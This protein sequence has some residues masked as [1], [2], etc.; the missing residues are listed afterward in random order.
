MCGITGFISKNFKKN[1]L[2]KM[3]ESLSHRGPDASGQ[4]FDSK[5]GIALGHR[6][7]SILD[8]SN[9]ANQPM[10]SHCE[11]YVMVFNGEI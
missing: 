8:L 3:T 10:S 6:R 4:F 2:V 9:T 1:D 5:K 11:R 7:L